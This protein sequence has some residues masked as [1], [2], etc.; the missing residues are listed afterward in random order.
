MPQQVNIDALSE[1]AA[2][3]YQRYFD[4]SF[5]SIPIFNGSMRED[6]LEGLERLETACPQNGGDIHID[7][8][9]RGGG[10]VWDCSMG[11]PS[12]QPWVAL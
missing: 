11:M 3:N 9:V 10:G 2:Y 8:L 6:F 5:A 12:D 7:A 4:H 1:L